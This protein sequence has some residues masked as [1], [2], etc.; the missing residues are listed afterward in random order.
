MEMKGEHAVAAPTD[1]VWKALND[2]AVLKLCIP[3]C[4]SI[5]PDGENA[6]RMAMATKVGPVSARFTGKVRLSDIEP[7]HSYTIRFEG[8]GGV[9]GF[10]NGE[11]RVS[12]LPVSGGETTLTYTAKAQI[13]GKLAQV[14]SRLIDGAA[15]KLTGDF[16][17]RFVTSLTPTVEMPVPVVERR[18]T[19]PIPAPSRFPWRVATAAVLVVLAIVYLLVR[20]A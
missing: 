4:E 5:E 14:G 8:N 20:R 16:F 2:P 7:P 19:V 3:G 9:A 11:A 13:G 12:L 17:N 15:H 1:H 10:V 6:Y 18:A